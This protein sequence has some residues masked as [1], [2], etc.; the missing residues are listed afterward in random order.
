VTDPDRMRF[1]S[2]LFYYRPPEEMIETFS[3]IPEAVKNTLIIADKTDLLIK[4]DQFLLPNYTVP[5]GFTPDTYLEKLCRE[6][7]KKRYSE[8]KKEHVDRLEHELNIIKKMGF[9]SYFLIVWDFIKYA[10]DNGI[11][12]GPGRGSG[13]GSIVAYTLG[14]TD[15]CP[16]RYDLLFERFL[17]P[18]RR[19]MPDLDIDFAD[20]GRDKVIEYVRNKYGHNNCAQIITYGSM[21]AK[22]VVKDVA[23]AMGFSPSEGQKI[24]NAIPNGLSIG[25]A[26]TNSEELQKIIKSD[27][28]IA[29]LIKISAKLEGIKRHTG[30]HAAGMVIAPEDIRRYSPLAKDQKT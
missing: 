19:T 22:M 13:A 16:L 2:D 12:V 25:A 15:I 9:D 26:K 18:D 17:N 30:V 29:E 14:I 28:K 7:L 8:V 20:F 6:G 10:K 4:K 23:R 5:E 24:A 21:K 11:P 1:G 27:E 3:Y